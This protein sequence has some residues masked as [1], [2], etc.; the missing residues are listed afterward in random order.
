MYEAGGI[1]VERQETSV[2][3]QSLAAPLMAV[4]IC[5]EV[6]GTALCALQ[7]AS[8]DGYKIRT[9]RFNYN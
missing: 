4:T 1:G 6:G 9:F 3:A 2:D 8:G 7:S 5:V